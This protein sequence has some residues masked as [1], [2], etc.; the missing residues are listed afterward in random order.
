MYMKKSLS[1][2][3]AKM[4]VSIAENE[5]NGG[6]EVTLARTIA[7]DDDIVFRGE[8]LDNGLVLVA[9]FTIGLDDMPMGL[10]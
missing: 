5:S 7:A 3:T 9:V 8:G 6:E 1:F 4:G 10:V 2:L